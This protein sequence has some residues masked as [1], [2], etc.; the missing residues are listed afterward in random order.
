MRKLRLNLTVIRAQCM[1]HHAAPRWAPS[2]LIAGR[3]STVIAPLT[4]NQARSR[5]FWIY[6]K[7]YSEGRTI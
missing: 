3:T 5:G 6:N 1:R 7:G 2:L 4:G